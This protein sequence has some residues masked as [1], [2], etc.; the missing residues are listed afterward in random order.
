MMLGAKFRNEADTSSFVGSLEQCTTPGR[1]IIKAA[2]PTQCILGSTHKIVRDF[3]IS[4][5]FELQAPG[6]N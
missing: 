2:T 1:V 6:I 5:D 3:E 4:G